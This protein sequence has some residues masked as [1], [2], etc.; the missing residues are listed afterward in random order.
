[1]PV[2]PQPAVVTTHS[3]EATEAFGA[4]LGARLR[5]G[6]VVALVG[7]L[8]AGKT[9][10]ARGI[11]IGA[12]ATG[13]IASPSFVLIREYDGPIRIYHIDLYR[14]ERREDVA[15][16]GLEDLLGGPAI[17]VVEWADRAPWLLPADH[18]LVACALASDEQTRVFTLTVPPSMRGRLAA[19]LGV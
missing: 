1:M 4:R 16:L 3:P 17:A 14:L 7:P 11:A 5:A 18:L 12:G 15:Y 9:V 19:A 13:Y 8:G 6:D 10:F 2:A